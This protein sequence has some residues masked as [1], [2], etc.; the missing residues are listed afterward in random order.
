MTRDAPYY[1]LRG[2]RAE[3]RARP[4]GDITIKPASHDY[5]GREVAVVV[6]ADWTPNYYEEVF[7][8]SNGRPL[9]YMSDVAQ[10]VPRMASTREVTVAAE[11]LNK[12]LT[13]ARR[14]R[15]AY[16]PV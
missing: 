13:G 12:T 5:R 11:L 14:L 2:D 9:I 10:V 3:P 8:T 16:T 15:Q 7:T 6:G 1:V 4:T